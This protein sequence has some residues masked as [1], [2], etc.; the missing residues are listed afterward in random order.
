MTSIRIVAV[1]AF[2]SMCG[3]AAVVNFD[4]LAAGTAV[5]TQYASAGVRFVGT[6]RVFN[7]DP[8]GGA[9]LFPSPPNS[10]HLESSTGSIIFVAP[11]NPSVRG[12]T[13]SV[14]FTNNGLNSSGG[15]YGGMIVTARD[16]NGVVLGTAR[17]EPVGPNRS[18]ANT[19]IS[20]TVEGIHEINFTVI[21]HPLGG[22]YV[23]FDDLTFNTPIA[24]APAAT[25]L[26]RNSLLAAGG[27]RHSILRTQA[28]PV[29]PFQ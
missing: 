12:V 8:T 6:F 14:S 9:M 1:F 18:R 4:N 11:S 17:I 13:N 16:V 26:P 21:S 28:T 29:C 27:I 15:Y 24:A 3:R 23:P 10:I 5:D 19:P 20:F 2:A 22:A 25:I 7:L